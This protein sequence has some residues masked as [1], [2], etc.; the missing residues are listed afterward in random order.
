MSWVHTFVPVAW[1]VFW[2]YWLVSAVGAK[3][4]SR[5]APR[6]PGALLLFVVVCVL[7][8]THTVRVGSSALPAPGCSWPAWRCSWPASA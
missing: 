6:F 7:A 2:E 5:L 3:H 8:R 1:L 4:G